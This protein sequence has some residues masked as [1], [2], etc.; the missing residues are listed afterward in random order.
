MMALLHEDSHKN[1]GQGQ[2][3]G[4]MILTVNSGW[5]TLYKTCNQLIFEIMEIKSKGDS[6]LQFYMVFLHCK[7]YVKIF[8]W[9]SLAK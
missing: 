9:S 2:Q 5:L 8:L 7:N 1:Q 6:P 4:H 3:F